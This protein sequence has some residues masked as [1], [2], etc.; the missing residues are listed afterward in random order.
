MEDII[1]L[2]A[3]LY[4]FILYQQTGLYLYPPLS[5]AT[6]DANQPY[7]RCNQ[8]CQNR[9]IKKD[10]QEFIFLPIGF[11]DNSSFRAYLVRIDMKKFQLLVV[12]YKPLRNHSN[13]D[14]F[15]RCSF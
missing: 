11:I 12:I 8:Q 7:D 5:L 1:K 3:L 10:K 4:H 15:G 14:V 6:I 2:I 13:P 9:R